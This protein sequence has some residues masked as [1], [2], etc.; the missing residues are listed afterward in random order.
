[1]R[2]ARV[3]SVNRR[4]ILSA[5]VLVIVAGYVGCLEQ[6]QEGAVEGAIAMKVGAMPDE[7]VLPYYVAER[8]GIF[9]EHGLDVEI[10]PFMSAME[11]DSALIAG[12][13][14]A[15]ENDP[16]GVLVLRNAD[17]NARVVSLE[18]YETPEKMRFAIIASPHSNITSV[19]DLEGKNIAIS[20]NTVMEWIADNLLGNVTVNKIEEKRVP[21][22]MQMLLEDK[23]DAATL[24]DP[25]A[26]YAIYKGAT[27]VISDSELNETIGY[28]VIV[29][30]GEFIEE[31]PESV[32]QFLAAY[33]E[34]VERINANP[35]NYRDLLVEVA[36][37]P[38]EIAESYQMATYMKA[39]QYP[40][41]N[42]EKVLSWMQSKGL[43]TQ[44]IVYEDVV[45]GSAG[46]D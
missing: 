32:A 25:L 41:D 40:R 9:L 44:E 3:M 5:V 11:R 28:T 33:N 24:P 2:N 10:V 22:R 20:N 42:F 31:H 39:Q 7:A 27:K 1:M 35:E 26:S 38:E 21:I 8:E 12:E 30:R 37:V 6:P 45:Y 36:K 23:Y 4:L 15:E 34:A 18:M 14:D 16:V 46:H 13:I 19:A 29:F 43:V 17:Y